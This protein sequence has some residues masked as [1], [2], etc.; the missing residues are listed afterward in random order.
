MN[1]EKKLA[2]YRMHNRKFLPKS[3]MDVWRPISA[4]CKVCCFEIYFVKV[5]NRCIEALNINLFNLQSDKNQ[6]GKG[7]GYG[8]LEM[9]VRIIF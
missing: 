5:V 6:V 3:E 7:F 1:L 9:D 2:D 4:R 8:V